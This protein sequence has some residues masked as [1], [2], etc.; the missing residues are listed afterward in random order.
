MSQTAMSQ[1]T[2]KL[3][4]ICAD[5]IASLVDLKWH[6]L[7]TELTAEANASLS[8]LGFSTIWRIHYEILYSA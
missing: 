7:G 3:Q 1:T 4:K 8:V 2:I 6:L 5:H